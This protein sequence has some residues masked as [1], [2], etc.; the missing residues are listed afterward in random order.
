MGEVEKGRVKRLAVHLA[1]PIQSVMVAEFNNGS[2]RTTVLRSPL[3]NAFVSGSCP[4]YLAVATFA[5]RGNGM[6][7]TFTI[8]ENAFGGFSALVNIG[9]EKLGLLAATVNTQQLTLDV[10]GL[11]S[12]LAAAIETDAAVLDQAFDSVLIP[13]SGLRAEFRMPA[14]DFVELLTESIKEQNESWL[15]ANR[16]KWD[17]VTPVVEKLICPNSF[18]EQLSKAYRLLMNRPAIVGDLR[19]LTELRPVYDDDVTSVHA[20][21]I[22]STLAVI[23]QESGEQKRIHLTLDRKDLQRLQEQVER[24]LKKIQLLEKQV[25][26][27]DVPSLVAGSEES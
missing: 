1:Y 20:Y 19:V 17:S 11:T 14:P 9:P 5:G 4:R 27:L 25:S 3:Q 22:T 6:A 15:N 8:P 26:L 16:E 21:L 13:L 18:F 23:Y 24:G 10:S 7:N 12:R 2:A